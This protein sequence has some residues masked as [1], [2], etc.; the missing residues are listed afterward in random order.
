MDSR[1]LTKTPDNLEEYWEGSV[2]STL[3]GMFVKEYSKKMWKI[4]NNIELDQDIAFSLKKEPVR[5]GVK[6]YFEG[7]VPLFISYTCIP[8]INSWF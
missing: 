5:S 3:Y 4:K 1:D 8:E 6:E 2:G 7:E